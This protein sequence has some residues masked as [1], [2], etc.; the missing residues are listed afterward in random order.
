MG[1]RFARPDGWPS[2]QDDAAQRVGW[3]NWVNWV[4]RW[5]G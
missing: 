4:A 5:T 2:A 1:E 3:V